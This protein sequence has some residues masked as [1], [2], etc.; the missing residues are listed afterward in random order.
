MARKKALDIPA[1]LR[2]ARDEFEDDAHNDHLALG[3]V[4]DILEHLH[5]IDAELPDEAGE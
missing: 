3:H 1:K 2:A 4:L 5:G